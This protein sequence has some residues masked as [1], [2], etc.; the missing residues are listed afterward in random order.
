VQEV[1]QWKQL[2]SDNARR[3]RADEILSMFVRPGAPKLINIEEKHLKQAVKAFD[4]NN[5]TTLFDTCMTE[6]FKLMKLD[7]YQRFSRS[8]FFS[9]MLAGLHHRF[10]KHHDSKNLLKGRR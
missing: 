4:E 9:A 10:S 5:V 8:V 7:S 1:S 3:A 2:G 6:V